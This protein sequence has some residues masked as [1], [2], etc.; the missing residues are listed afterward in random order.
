[1]KQEN[2][3]RT[4]LETPAGLKDT[5]KW[6]GRILRVKHSFLLKEAHT[7]VPES[8]PAAHH[9]FEPIP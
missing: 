4:W 6:T 7:E 3:H 1:M 2:D 9:Y 8:R 5:R